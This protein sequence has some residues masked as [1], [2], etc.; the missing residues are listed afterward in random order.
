[1]RLSHHFICKKLGE[2]L[3]L[4]STEHMFNRQLCFISELLFPLCHAKRFINRVHPA[5]SL[6]CSL[7]YFEL[8]G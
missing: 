1:M 6:L 2:R 8:P 7:H 5:K 3:S 4:F